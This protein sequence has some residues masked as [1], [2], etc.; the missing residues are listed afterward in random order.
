MQMHLAFIMKF[1]QKTFKRGEFRVRRKIASSSIRYKIHGQLLGS[2]DSSI[3]GNQK[4]DGGSVPPV[5]FPLFILRTVHYS[6][7]EQEGWKTDCSLTRNSHRRSSEEVGGIS[8]HGR[9]AMYFS[10]GNPFTSYK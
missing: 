5:A 8:G 4:E 3:K 9:S 6:V 7:R 2:L 10:V 1:D